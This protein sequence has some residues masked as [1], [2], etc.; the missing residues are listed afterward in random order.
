M[1][2]APQQ[3]TLFRHVN[4][5]K[6][7]ENGAFCAK[8]GAHFLDIS[9]SKSAPTLVRFA[10]FELEMCFVPQ[11]CAFFRHLNFQ[12]CSEHG[13]FCRFWIGNVLGATRACTFSTSQFLKV[14]RSWGVLC[15]L[16]W[17]V[18]RALTACNFSSLIWPDGSAPA[19]L[20]ILLFDL[21]KKSDARLSYLFAR[22]R[23]LSSDSFSCLIFSLLF[24][25]LLTLTTF[26]VLPV[27]IVE[28][29]T[30]KFPSVKQSSCGRFSSRPYSRG[31]VAGLA[32]QKQS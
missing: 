3:R 29:L 1:W 14:L 16:T 22:L 30:S 20:A 6:W 28:S 12:K 23:L 9:T 19:A 24:F 5:K 15:I 25:S 10:N 2:F 31:S 26:A 18:L 7:S 27:H 13:V 8:N 17:H 21:E 4:F 11:R 32:T